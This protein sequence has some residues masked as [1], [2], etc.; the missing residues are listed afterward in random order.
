MKAQ[1]VAVVDYGAANRTSVLIALERAGAAPFLASSAPAIASADAI[2]LPGVAHA[3]YILRRS[4][5]MGVRDEIARACSEGKPILGIC[6]GFQILCETSDEAPE[7]RGFGIF[8]GAVRAL[9][10]PRRLHVGWSRIEAGSAIVP[11]GWAYFTHGYALHDSRASV[12]TA[13]FGTQTF[14]AAARTGNTIGVQFH[15]ERSGAYGQ[16]FLQQFLSLKGVAHAG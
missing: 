12:A 15:P 1:R 8:D 10:G 16:R 5:Q 3:G 11:A 6:A 13:S 2:V 4:E 7:E 14:C 9:R